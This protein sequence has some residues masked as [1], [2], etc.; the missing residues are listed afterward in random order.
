MQ[1]RYLAEES[2]WAQA[3]EQQGAYVAVDSPQKPLGFIALGLVDGEAYLDQISVHPASMRQG[4]GTSLLSQAI[5]WSGARRLWLTTYAHLSWNRPYYELHGFVVVAE[6][7]LGP[8][9]SS[10]IQAQRS[11]LPEP[12]QRIA[13]VRPPAHDKTRP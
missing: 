13:M 6:C 2:R 7:E 10:I 12:E 4:I 11:A 9:L 1:K 5:S 8:E 3:I